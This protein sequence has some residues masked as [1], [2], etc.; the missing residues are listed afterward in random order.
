MKEAHRHCLHH[1]RHHQSLEI[2]KTRS[3]SCSNVKYPKAMRYRL[4]VCSYRKW[5]IVSSSDYS[6]TRLEICSREQLAMRR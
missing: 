6:R 3:T 5:M 1:R 2:H 4:M